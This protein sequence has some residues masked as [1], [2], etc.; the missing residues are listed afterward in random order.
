M[1]E[2]GPGDELPGPLF[3][4]HAIELSLTQARKARG[5]FLGAVVIPQVAPHGNEVEDI[6]VVVTVGVICS[7]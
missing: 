1:T 3:L 2:R 7:W 5:C 4:N 6:Y